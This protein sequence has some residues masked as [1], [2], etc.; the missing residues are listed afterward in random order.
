MRIRSRCGWPVEAD[1]EHVPYFPFIPVRGGPK[2]GKWCQAMLLFAK[3]DFDA[4]ICVAIKREQVIDDREIA[5][6]LIVTMRPHALIDGREVVEHPVRADRFR[7]QIGASTLWM[8]S[9]ATQK[10]GMLS[11]RWLRRDCVSPSTN[12]VRRQRSRR[13]G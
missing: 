13:R 11:A 7:L 2:V 1:A 3:R 9:G 12:G 5:G 8:F 10:V 6:R 4:D